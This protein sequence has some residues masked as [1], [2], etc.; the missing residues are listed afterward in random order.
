MTFNTV[1]HSKNSSMNSS[2]I[3]NPNIERGI[4]N[5]SKITTNLEDQ[6]RKQRFDLNNKR[7][8]YRIKNCNNTQIGH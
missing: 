1:N 5:G 6:L 8:S 4:Y 7:F 2:R 3:K